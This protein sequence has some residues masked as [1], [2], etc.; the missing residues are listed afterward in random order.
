MHTSMVAKAI[1]NQLEA[2]CRAE[3][4]TVGSLVAAEK[5]ML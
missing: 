4:E 1:G 2:I 3:V 5:L